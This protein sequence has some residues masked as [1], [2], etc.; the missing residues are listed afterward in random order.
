MQQT[1][2][3]EGHRKRCC[4]CQGDSAGSDI[5]AYRA[6]MRG[7]FSRCRRRHRPSRFFFLLLRLLFFLLHVIFVFFFSLALSLSLSLSLTR[8][9]HLVFSSTATPLTHTYRERD[10]ERVLMVSQ[11]CKGL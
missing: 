2:E 6:T 1:E 3:D 4:A 10:I 7:D 5:H 8:R 11:E 9:L